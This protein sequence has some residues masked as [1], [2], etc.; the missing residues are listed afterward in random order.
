MINIPKKQYRYFK[1]A[2]KCTAKIH[3]E[4]PD[5][6]P[7]KFENGGTGSLLECRPTERRAAGSIPVWGQ[8]I[9]LNPR[10]YDP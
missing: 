9:C 6:D 4:N 1:N 7:K 3:T 8:Y 5:P 2:K 10:P